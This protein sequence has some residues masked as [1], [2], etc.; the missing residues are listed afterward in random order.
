MSKPL[1]SFLFVFPVT[2]GDPS[3]DSTQTGNTFF[4]CNAGD[5]DT[6]TDTGTD[7]YSDDDGVRLGRFGGRRRRVLGWG[8]ILR[9]GWNP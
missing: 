8:A 3:L 1:V 9:E 4:F 7:G 5:M 2:A 6:D